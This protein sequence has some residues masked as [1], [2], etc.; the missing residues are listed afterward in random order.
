MKKRDKILVYE[1]KIPQVISMM[2]D[3]KL[4]DVAE[5]TGVPTKV[6]VDACIEFGHAEYLTDEE[7]TPL[8]PDLFYSKL[9]PPAEENETR[10]ERM[11]R[12]RG[13]IVSYQTNCPHSRMIHRCSRCMK[14]LGS[15]LTFVRYSKVEEAIN[16]TYDD[17]WCDTEIE[18]NE[19]L[20]DMRRTF[21]RNLDATLNIET[22]IEAQ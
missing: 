4:E 21:M 2:R 8:I 6:I 19:L 7:K 12:I 11:D 1:K 18:N 13:A 16:K 10:E 14:V 20:D 9:I 15:E 17:L 22:K 3:T 5:F